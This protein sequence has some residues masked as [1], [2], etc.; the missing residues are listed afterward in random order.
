MDE[1]NFKQFGE[2][3]DTLYRIMRQSD[4]DIEFMIS[5]YYDGLSEVYDTIKELNGYKDRSDD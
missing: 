5:E 3:L 2:C 1:N 4:K